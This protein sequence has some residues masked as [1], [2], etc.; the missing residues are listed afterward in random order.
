MIL[1]QCILLLLLWFLTC[2]FYL[3]TSNSFKLRHFNHIKTS[4]KL[5]MYVILRMCQLKSLMNI[6]MCSLIE[7]LT[8][9]YSLE[10]GFFTGHL[11]P[12]R[13]LVFSYRSYLGLRIAKYYLLSVFCIFQIL[14]TRLSSIH[15]AF[16]FVWFHGSA[17]LHFFTAAAAP[18]AY[19]SC[20]RS[21]K[22]L[23]PSG[24]NFKA[25]NIMTPFLY[26]NG[27]ARMFFVSLVFMPLSVLLLM[28]AYFKSCS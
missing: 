10:K 14:D 12:L 28:G 5:I 3:L 13:F 25:K 7:L 9:E 4:V 1:H 8:T 6:K 18:A 17:R 15:A 20:S 22:E 27:F 21:C 26:Y 23:Q 2:S 11:M 24:P 19:V 16:F